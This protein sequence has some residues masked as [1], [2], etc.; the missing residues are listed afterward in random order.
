MTYTMSSKAQSGLEKNSYGRTVTM[1]GYVG[2]LR[3]GNEEEKRGLLD[4]AFDNSDFIG[5][6]N[7]EVSS[8]KIVVDGEKYGIG[9]G[10]YDAMVSVD[11]GDV[12]VVKETENRSERKNSIRMAAYKVK[13]RVGSL[14]YD[15][16]LTD[17]IEANSI[18]VLTDSHGELRVKLSSGDV[19]AMR[20]MKE[21]D[22]I[23]GDSIYV[24][25]D[26][27][28]LVISTVLH[29]SGAD[30][31]QME[32]FNSEILPKAKE[33]F[34]NAVDWETVRFAECEEETQKVGVC[35]SMVGE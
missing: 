3:D 18:N 23:D 30:P 6:E 27:E 33:R 9:E 4:G 2:E 16:N 20:M 7:N 26:T 8:H 5:F 25:D 21:Q 34:R 22:N 32:W 35:S 12:R 11:S 19:K 29:I 17:D 28:Y 1:F 31:V 15:Y 24:D 13:R 10:L 14:K